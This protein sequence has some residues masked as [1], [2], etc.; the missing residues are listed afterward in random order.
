MS[1]TTSGILLASA[2]TQ[3]R[4]FLLKKVLSSVVLESIDLSSVKKQTT[5]HLSAT[6]LSDTQRDQPTGHLWVSDK[7][8]ACVHSG[9]SWTIK[10]FTPDLKTRRAVTVGSVLEVGA[11][12]NYKNELWISGRKSV[13]ALV[14]ETMGQRETLRGGAGVFIVS[15]DLASGSSNWSY[16]IPHSAA[17]HSEGIASY[18]N[19]L[20]WALSYSGA[21]QLGSV[22]LQ[23]PAPAVSSALLVFADGKPV[24]IADLKPDNSK[25]SSLRINTILATGADSI[26]FSADLS[27]TVVLDRLRRGAASVLCSCK[28]G[29]AEVEYIWV[30]ETSQLLSS[31]LGGVS[32]GLL[33]HLVWNDSCT[34]TIGDMVFSDTADGLSQLLVAINP[35]GEL[36]WK[37]IGRCDTLLWLPRACMTGQTLFLSDTR[38]P[39]I[40]Y[41]VV[42]RTLNPS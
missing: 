31:S 24:R 28:I 23:T 5:D 36:L 18:A 6:I 14:I 33:W 30:A 27:G 42:T 35:T 11:C 38:R 2:S 29:I 7:I 20:F 13:S 8:V 12:H 25:D 19:R 32:A 22:R 15:L 40:D 41:L 34:L 26:V 1:T 37:V 21:L 17:V 9:G 4:L 16:V 10:V 39:D 3:E